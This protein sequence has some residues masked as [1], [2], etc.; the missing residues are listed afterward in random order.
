MLHITQEH[1]S[2]PLLCSG[3]HF[4]IIYNVIT[5]EVE[6]KGLELYFPHRIL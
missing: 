3:S 6:T 1:Y 2:M 5:D 4:R